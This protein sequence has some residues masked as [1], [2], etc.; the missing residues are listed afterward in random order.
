MLS[1]LQT[2]VDLLLAALQELTVMLGDPVLRIAVY[3]VMALASVTLLM[4]LNVLVLSELATRRERRRAAFTQ[5]WRPVLTAWS[6]GEYEKFPPLTQKRQEERLWLL[7]MWVSLQR[8]LRGSTKEKLNAFFNHLVMDDYV[9]ALLGSRK[10]HRRL[11]ALTCLRY[12]GEERHWVSVAPLVMSSNAI[13][14]LAAAQVLVAMNPARAM[15]FLVPFYM[16]RRDWAYLRFKSLCKQAG[17]TAAGPP[18]L[19]A[20]QQGSPMRI[21]ALLEWVLPAKAAGWARRCL[22]QTPVSVEMSKEQCDAVCASLRCLAELHDRQDRELLINALDHPLPQVRAEAVVAFKR[23][24]NS[25]D[26]AQFIR[27]LSDS[28]WWV[29]QAAADALVALPGIE[30]HHLSAL[31]EGLQD[32]YGRDALRR[33][34]TEKQ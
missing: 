11:L 14:S 25:D 12:V 8:Q 13:E 30:A 26:E 28:N 27:V 19:T 32:R 29:R 16:Q 33:A 9:V 2:L 22:H 4:M 10:V 15:Q 3:S 31:Y 20:L 18:L 6:I 1:E 17:R 23:Q 24:A 7:L 21:V 34:M 5:L